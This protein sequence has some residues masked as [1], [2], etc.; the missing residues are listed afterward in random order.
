MKKTGNK[1]G[2][3]NCSICGGSHSGFSGKIDAEGLEYVIC[4]NA[5]VTLK[6]HGE[7]KKEISK[8]DN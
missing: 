5:K 8:T 2:T 4:R 1:W 3:D 7:Y 6:Y